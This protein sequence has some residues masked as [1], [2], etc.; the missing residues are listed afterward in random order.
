MGQVIANMSQ[1]QVLEQTGIA[2]LAQA[3]QNQ[4]IVLKLLP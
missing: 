2:S 1:F 4:Q 3:N